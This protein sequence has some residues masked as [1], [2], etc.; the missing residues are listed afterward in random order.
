MAKVS[1]GSA[2]PPVD[3]RRSLAMDSGVQSMAIRGWGFRRRSVGSGD[4]GSAFAAD[5]GG[6]AFAAGGELRSCHGLVRR[7]ALKLFLCQDPA[8]PFMRRACGARSRAGS[9]GCL[10]AFPPSPE[11]FGGG[12]SCQACALMIRRG[13]QAFEGSTGSPVSGT[14]LARI[15]EAVEND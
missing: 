7:I 10:A 3:L 15:K 8:R 5:D 2:W 11:G 9:P 13:S 12:G 14:K 4:G 1:T 6:S